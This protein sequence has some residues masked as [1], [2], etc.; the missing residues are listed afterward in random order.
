MSFAAAG[1]AGLSAGAEPAVGPWTS[2]GPYEDAG[3]LG[4]HYAMLAVA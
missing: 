2:D 4:E 3:P 1:D